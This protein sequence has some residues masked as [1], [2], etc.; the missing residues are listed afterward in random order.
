MV[1]TGYSGLCFAAVGRVP[2]VGWPVRRC[3]VNAKVPEDSTGRF[4]ILGNYITVWNVVE[5]EVGGDLAMI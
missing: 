5:V 2:G 3:L 4:L 1:A